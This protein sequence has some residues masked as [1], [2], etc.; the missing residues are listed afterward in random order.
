MSNFKEILNNIEQYV[1]LSKEDENEFSSILSEISINKKEF[2]IKPGDNYTALY[3][4]KKGAIRSFT[5]DKKGVE[6]TLRLAVDD[7]FISDLNSYINQSKAELYVQALEDSVVFQ[8]KHTQVEDLCFKNTKIQYYFRKITER[9]YSYSQKRILSNLN[10]TAK[11]RYLDYYNRYPEIVN[12]IPQYVLASYLRM[13]PEFLS[14][15]RQQLS[16]K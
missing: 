4:V 16:K 11:E 7:W 14:K 1:E 3:Y 9:A 5:V 6:H 15:I 13:T 10:K 8:M 2:L 12:K